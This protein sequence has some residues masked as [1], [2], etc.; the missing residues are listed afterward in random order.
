MSLM[1]RAGSLPVLV[2]VTRTVASTF[3]TDLGFRGVGLGFRMGLAVEVVVDFAM[4]LNG[5][6]RCDGWLFGVG[7]GGV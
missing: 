4:F 1:T 5:A 3:A 7:E 6:F 2:R